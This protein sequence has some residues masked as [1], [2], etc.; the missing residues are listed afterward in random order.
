MLSIEEKRVYGDRDEATEAYVSS[1]MGV[2]RVRI[3]GDN[4]GEFSLCARCDARDVAAS[5]GRVAVATDE[6]ALV[7]ASEESDEPTFAETGFGPAVAVGYVDERLVAAGPD[8]RVARLEANGKWTVLE[9]KGGDE[10][11]TATIDE[12]RAIDGDLV[13]TDDGVYRVHGDELEHAGLSD[14]RDVGAAG[15]PLAAT[16]D[17][18]Y[19]LGN[20]WMKIYERPFDAVAA[21]SRSSP[22]SL[23]RAHAVSDRSVYEYVDEEWREDETR[24]NADDRIVAIDYDGYLYAVTETGTV[25]IAGDG[26]WRGR[27]IG[28]RDVTGLAVLR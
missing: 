19:K 13:G 18:L 9:P 14:V 3:A 15:V 23:S 24:A 28:V 21:D 11:R 4:V 6:D 27:S 7:L 1:P 12:V 10:R 16:G 17:G 2:V 22:G 25:E 8:G 26:E 20:G 5:D